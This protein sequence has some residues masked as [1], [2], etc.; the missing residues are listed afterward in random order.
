MPQLHTWQQIN[1]H[2]SSWKNAMSV[3]WTLSCAMVAQ[4]SNFHLPT[5]VGKTVLNDKTIQVFMFGCTFA[6]YCNKCAEYCYANSKS[7]MKLY[8]VTSKSTESAVR[9]GLGTGLSNWTSRVAFQ[10]QLCRSFFPNFQYHWQYLSCL[11][12]LTWLT[13][14]WSY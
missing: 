1:S 5:S 4:K 8:L 13:C 6:I 7:A 14:H 3:V 12:G 2:A 9:A 11:L 10:Q